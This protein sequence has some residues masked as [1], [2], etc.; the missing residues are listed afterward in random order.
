MPDYW[1][2]FSTKYHQ[3]CRLTFADLENEKTAQFDA[4]YQ[5]EQGA[6]KSWAS[7]YAGLIQDYILVAYNLRQVQWGG[8]KPKA[9]MSMQPLQVL[10]QV[11]LTS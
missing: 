11:W 10:K 7:V 6:F 4:G 2:L 9:E 3:K 5:Y 1:E 8:W